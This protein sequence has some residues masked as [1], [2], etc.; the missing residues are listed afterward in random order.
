MKAQNLVCVLCVVLL[1]ATV[2]LPQNL[3]IG[4]TGGVNLATVSTDLEATTPKILAGFGIGG[5]LDVALADNLTLSV[6]P[7]YLQKGAKLE[8]P[9]EEADFDIFGEMTGKFNYSYIEIPVLFKY[10]LGSGNTRPYL[11]A[12]PSI[13]ILTKAEMGLELGDVGSITV[14]IKDASESLDFGIALGGGIAF[15]LGDNSLF[16]EAR[17]T[18]G[19]VDVLNGM[20]ASEEDDEDTGI[21]DG[22]VNHRGFQIMA[23]LS[24]P[25]GD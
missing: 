7:M 1:L 21:E 5:V 10:A 11:A 13:G 12:G 22:K 4:V 8:Y 15:P 18:L 16:V 17:Y 20:E 3:R 6:Q 14:D 24:F 23:G 19:L 9:M 25:L 2:V